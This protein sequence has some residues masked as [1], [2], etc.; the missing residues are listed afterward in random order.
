M[1]VLSLLLLLLLLLFVICDLLFS[2]DVDRTRSER[3]FFFHVK[4]EYSKIEKRTPPRQ[5][6]GGGS[7]LGEEGSPNMGLLVV[8]RRTARILSLQVLVNRG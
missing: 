2:F 5:L 7:Y 3:M 6:G 4:P 8:T 1:V